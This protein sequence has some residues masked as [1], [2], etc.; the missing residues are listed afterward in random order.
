MSACVCLAVFV[1]SRKNG[2]LEAYIG[3][4]DLTS[5]GDDIH[6]CI[7]VDKNI[8]CKNYDLEDK[9]SEYS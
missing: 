5:D 3:F 7:D 8:I 4:N 2:F 9:M 1:R 6:Y